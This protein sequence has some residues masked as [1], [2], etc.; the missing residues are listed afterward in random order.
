MEKFLEKPKME[1]LRQGIPASDDE[2]WGGHH[3]PEEN[4]NGIVKEE[5]DS[6]DNEDLTYITSILDSFSKSKSNSDQLN[7]SD[8]A[9]FMPEGALTRATAKQMTPPKF[10]QKFNQNSTI[11]NSAAEKFSCFPTILEEGPTDL[12]D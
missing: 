11:K 7:D 6:W 4:E 5:V 12:A 3:W 9:I 1:L 8:C 10:N 2:D